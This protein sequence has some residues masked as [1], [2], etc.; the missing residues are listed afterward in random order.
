[1]DN[2]SF[3]YQAC[4]ARCQVD[5]K[6]APDCFEPPCSNKSY[7]PTVNCIEKYLLSTAALGYAIFSLL[8][9]TLSPFDILSTPIAVVGCESRLSPFKSTDASQLRQRN[10]GNAL[11]K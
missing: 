7:K 1:M 11:I 3:Q 5:R 10:Q 2:A 8:F 4:M 6:T 9:H